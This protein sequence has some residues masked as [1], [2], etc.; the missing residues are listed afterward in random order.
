MGIN[1]FWRM[2]LM[3]VAIILV[4]Q[5]TKAS[6]QTNFQLGES[7]PIIKGFFNLTYVRNT[8]AAF[9]MGAG[10]K[11]WLRQVLF[12]ALPT[13]ICFGL[14]YYIIRYINS[15]F[16][17]ILAYSLILAGAIGNLIDRFTLKFVVDFLDFYIGNSHFPAFNV[18]D[19]AITI[20]GVIVA[21]DA[22]ILSRKKSDEP[23]KEDNVEESV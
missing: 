2:T 3:M 22:F 1:R 18:A 17:M 19:S 7:I 14:L 10:S 12:L 16:H 13:L 6:V 20:G 15:A 5:L 4:D 8:G 23:E 9:G 11:E 21:Y